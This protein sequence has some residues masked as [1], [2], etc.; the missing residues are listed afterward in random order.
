MTK[1][2]YLSNSSKLLLICSCLLFFANAFTVLVG[3]DT[4]L[5]AYSEKISTYCFYIVAVLGFLAFNGEGIAYK[6]SKEKKSRNKTRIL[7]LLLIAAFLVRFIKAPVEDFALSFSAEA[8]SGI[9][10]RMLLGVFNTVASYGF[11]LTAVALWYIFRDGGVGKLM[12]F[13]AVAFIFG[14]VY[15][16][17]KSFNYMVTKYE[18]YSLGSAFVKAF[19]NSEILRALCLVQFAA[20]IVMFVFVFKH[21][22]KNAIIEQEKKAAVMKKMVTARKIYNTDCVGIDTLEDSFFLK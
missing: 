14:L 18:L 15:N 17:Y 9:V 16:I 8:A 1:S 11:L 2:D 20:D 7:K 10:S 6:R 13:E 21:Y 19:S 12:P 5:F 4:T 3:G 22:D